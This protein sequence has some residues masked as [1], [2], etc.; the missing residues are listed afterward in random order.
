MSAMIVFALS[1]LSAFDAFETTFQQGLDAYHDGRYTEAATAFEQLVASRVVDPVVFYNLGNTYFQQEHW[2]AAIANFER[3]LRLDPEMQAA[4]DNLRLAVARS[5]RARNAPPP[6]AWREALLF[7]DNSLG[8]GAVRALAILCW[9]AFWG[10]LAGQMLRPFPYR[11][12]A[13]ATLLVLSV[14]TSLSAYTKANPIP[15][16][17]VAMSE[18]PIRYGIGENEAIRFTLR[19]GDYVIV[20][21]EQQDWMRVRT[22]EG[23][24]G[25]AP[26]QVFVSITPPYDQFQA[27]DKV[28][29]AA[30]Q[31]SAVS[32]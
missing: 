24:R 27:E 13:V 25:W 19:E 12:T 22:A 18:A 14:L 32:L 29:P 4:R 6:P 26:Q 11:K 31:E 20:E 30:S 9:L 15:S 3:T 28:A 7:W 8:Y 16:A 23:D 5:Q 10:A 2:G 1:A 17:I 21:E